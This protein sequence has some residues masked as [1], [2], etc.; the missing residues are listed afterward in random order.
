MRAE[1]Q[2]SSWAIQ[3]PPRR[4]ERIP[5]L[6]ARP[7]A[8]VG[9]TVGG[10]ARA[11]P[12]G[13]GGGGTVSQAIRIASVDL[14]AVLSADFQLS[15]SDPLLAGPLGLGR[16]L[17]AIARTEAARRRAG[18]G[19]TVVAR[20]LAPRPLPVRYLKPAERRNIDRV[21]ALGAQ[22]TVRRNRASFGAAGVRQEELERVIALP[23][24]AL[25][26]ELLEHLA[27]VPWPAWV[28]RL[29]FAR[30]VPSSASRDWVSWSPSGVT[31]PLLAARL[32]SAMRGPLFLRDASLSLSGLLKVQRSGMAM[33]S[34][35]LWLPLRPGEAVTGAVE[36]APK[37]R[38]G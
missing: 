12:V 2:S 9:S 36:E 23:E 37:R 16:V 31:S 17:V 15:W 34:W 38:A 4:W 14:P 3:G 8:G 24:G 29:A 6:E 27:A 10:E 21:R 25:I 20:P 28:P 1:R 22:E 30:W 32:L 11:V 18:P 33:T 35:E 7:R 19:A 26:S 13:P 5:C